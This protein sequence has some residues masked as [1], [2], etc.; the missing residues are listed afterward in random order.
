MIG[1]EIT[2][3]LSYPFGRPDGTDGMRVPVLSSIAV[4][5]GCAFSGEVMFTGE[6]YPPPD[7]AARP[8]S[9]APMSAP[10]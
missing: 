4:D 3:G 10:L 2:V 1:I 5:K 9:R 8:T 6:V 7:L